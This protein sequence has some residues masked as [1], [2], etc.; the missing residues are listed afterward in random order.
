M[1]AYQTDSLPPIGG[2]DEIDYKA[3]G[4]RI[5]H[6]RKMAGMTQEELAL[7][8]GYMSRSSVNQM[9]LGKKSIPVDKFKAL[10]KAF[11][12]STEE[13][14]EECGLD[15]RVVA[16]RFVAHTPTLV[17]EVSK[18]ILENIFQDDPR[19]LAVL[20]KCD[21]VMLSK[22]LALMPRENKE[23]IKMALFTGLK[24]A[25]VIK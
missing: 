16:V 15:S 6:L 8:I 23:L 11:D 9:E 13:L 4:R 5:K 12:L 21:S 25:K 1:G 22:R 2:M 19:T 18:G 7:K 3:I 24:E 17:K 14:A 10:A 20:K